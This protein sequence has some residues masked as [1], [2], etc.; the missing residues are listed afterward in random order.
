M[1]ASHEGFTPNLSSG[2]FVASLS[3]NRAVGFSDFHDHQRGDTLRRLFYFEELAAS[4][5][6]SIENIDILRWADQTTIN[7]QGGF[8]F[9]SKKELNRLVKELHEEQKPKRIE[10][11]KIG[12]AE[13]QHIFS[14]SN[15]WMNSHGIDSLKNRLGELGYK[16]TSLYGA[17]A[18]NLRSAFY[19]NE[20]IRR[21]EK[22]TSTFPDIN[23]ELNGVIEDGFFRYQSFNNEQITF[24]TPEIF[25]SEVIPEAGIDRRCS[26]GVLKVTLNV[27]NFDLLVGPHLNN[28]IVNGYITPY[29]YSNSW[30]NICWGNAS[31]QADEYRTQ[32][33]LR[34]FMGLF[35]ALLTTYGTDRPFAHLSSY[36]EQREKILDEKMRLARERKRLEG[37]KKKTGTSTTPIEGPLTVSE[38]RGP[39]SSLPNMFDGGP[40]IS[41]ETMRQLEEMTRRETERRFPGQLIRTPQEEI[42]H[43]ARQEEHAQARR[44]IR[45]HGPR[46]GDPETA[47]VRPERTPTQQAVAERTYSITAEDMNIMSREDESDI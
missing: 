42:R 6:V 10:R 40:P 36:L 27:G 24:L 12:D 43:R 9:K 23:E 33:H 3:A 5:E 34:K 46:L 4:Y 47:G 44:R 16:V 19:I 14:R 29:V 20:A 15:D 11:K 2:W 17:I 30:N 45:Q 35:Q 31:L 1:G 38:E 41:S 8:T 21:L 22:G 32:R 18:E 7:G 26:I 28:L 37:V 25:L 13:R 39:T